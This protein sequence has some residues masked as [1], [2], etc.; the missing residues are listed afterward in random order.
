MNMTGTKLSLKET[1]VVGV[2][3][4]SAQAKLN[5]FALWVLIVIMTRVLYKELTA[6]MLMVSILVAVVRL[7]LVALHC[8]RVA[9]CSLWWWR[10]VW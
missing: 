4:A 1:N 8:M 2:V 5:G 6:L 9:L 7:K 10:L 3:H